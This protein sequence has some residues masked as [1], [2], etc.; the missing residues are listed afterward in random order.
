MRAA[1][2]KHNEPS[3]HKWADTY[4]V[5]PVICPTCGERVTLKQAFFGSRSRGTFHA[6]DA[7]LPY[8]V[9]LVVE[10]LNGSVE[11]VLR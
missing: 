3:E 2:K 6:T 10:L 1:G 4:Q 7:C 11:A 5:P 8:R 9:K